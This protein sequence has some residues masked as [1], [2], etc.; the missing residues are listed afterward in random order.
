MPYESEAQQGWA[1]TAEGTKA[2]GGPEKVAE[3]DRASKGLKLPGHVQKHEQ[4]G[5]VM[6]KGT[7]PIQAH[8]AE[9]GAV[10]PRTGDWKKTVPNR[11]F[12]NS[13]DRFTSG[14]KV[15]GAPGSQMTSEAWKKDKAEG[16]LKSDRKEEKPVLPRS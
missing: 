15:Q 12:L 8:Y 10:L 14:R 4:G 11:G 9:G 7:G 2:L 16:N 1:H 13:P 5:P 3:W 6:T